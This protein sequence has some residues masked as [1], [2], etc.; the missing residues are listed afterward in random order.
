MLC[1]RWG[2]KFCCSNKFPGDGC[3][4]P[5]DYNLSSKDLGYRVPSP[6][7]HKRFSPTFLFDLWEQLWVLFYAIGC[8]GIIKYKLQWFT[9][10]I[11]PRTFRF[12]HCSVNHLVWWSLFRKVTYK[13]PEK[14][15]NHQFNYNESKPSNFKHLGQ[16]NTFKGDSPTSQHSLKINDHPTMLMWGLPRWH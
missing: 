6:Q 11:L 16:L 2:L 13:W 15:E 1:F 14:K 5:V 4:L 9:H 10:P 8:P 3:I 12:Q 7:L